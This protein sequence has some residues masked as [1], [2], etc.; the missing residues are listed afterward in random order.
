MRKLK[1]L[2]LAIIV[3]AIGI[4]TLGATVVASSSAYSGKNAYE[5]KLDSYTQTFNGIKNWTKFNG[6]LD[7]ILKQ[8]Q[9]TRE[10][11]PANWYVDTAI[12]D[13]ADKAIKKYRYVGNLRYL[14]DQ[15]IIALQL[16]RRTTSDP[17]RAFNYGIVVSDNIST[18]YYKIIC[19]CS[20]SD[21]DS[22]VY[23]YNKDVYSTNFKYVDDYTKINFSY[24]KDARILT[25]DVSPRLS[26]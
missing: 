9:M 23:R 12:I 7:G 19:K 17:L 14:T 16:G 20:E 3:A 25:A 1:K 18:G 6:Q 11:K 22:V 2:G 13:I 21:F 24:D 10:A 26:N 4:S 8:C 5:Y 15:G